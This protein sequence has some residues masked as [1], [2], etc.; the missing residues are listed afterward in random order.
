MSSSTRSS[1]R[2]SCCT[3]SCCST[4]SPRCSPSC[5]SLSPHPPPP[6][7]QPSPPLTD[8]FPTSYTPTEGAAIEQYSHIFR[9]PEGC[10]LTIDQPERVREHLAQWGQPDD[11]DYIVVT[12]AQEILGIGDQ[13]VGGIFISTAKLALCTLC[14]GLH[15]NRTLPVVLDCGT[16]RQSLL[17][18]SLYLG[19]RQK[20]VSSGPEYDGFVD[21]FVKAVGELYP[22]AVIHFEDF[23]LSNGRR[24]LNRYAE[25]RPVFND[26]V[27]GTG[28]IALAAITAGL[29]LTQ[30][31]IKDLRLVVF[32]FG[33]AGAGIADQ[34][35]DAIA[36]ECKISAEQAS[37]QILGVDKPGLLLQS[38]KEDL[39]DGQQSFAMHDEE[40]KG[41]GTDLLA[42]IREFKPNVLIGCSTKPGAFTEE[43]IREMVKHCERP[44]ILPL[45][46]PTRLIEATPEDLLHWTDGKALIAT[47][48]PFKPVTYKGQEIVI[49]ECKPSPLHPRSPPPQPPL[50]PS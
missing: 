25:D 29:H 16:D 13:G 22:R 19:L 44:I 14:A 4:T 5:P 50:P 1:C 47:G 31:T 37:G 36:T 8:P 6:P 48:S 41:Q 46:N 7:P 9:K 26:D 42:V 17:D 38:M 43:I 12:D 15:P 39:T 23:G 24:L 20:R 30:K 27:Q 34:V 33:S 2:T 49:S 40:W 28:C 11:I 3:T 21:T 18:D 10:F 45:S 32:G 35:R